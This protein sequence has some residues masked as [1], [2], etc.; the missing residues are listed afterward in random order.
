MREKY[1]KKLDV[2]LKYKQLQ[3][4]QYEE[5]EELFNLKLQTSEG[6]IEDQDLDPDLL[7]LNQEKELRDVIRQD[8]D[9]TLQEFDIFTKPEIKENLSN[10]LYLWAKDNNEFSYRQG[11]NEILAILVLAF[12]SE[13]RLSN[14][15]IEKHSEEQLSH[16][17]NEEII[18]ILF[19]EKHVYADIF[20][21]FDRIMS[22]GVKQ[23]Y[24]VT[25]DMAT[26]K[27]EIIQQ[28]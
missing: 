6:P 17:S 18:D 28:I 19:N 21:C 24:Q 2:T 12:F 13:Y 1:Y 5:A 26:L 7:I 16:L 25:K 9:R 10:I 8:I 27:K 23:L 11:M 3:E 4:K 22:L 15:Q 14:T 20:W